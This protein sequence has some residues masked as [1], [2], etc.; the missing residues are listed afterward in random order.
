M[1]SR[2]YMSPWFVVLAIVLAVAALIFGF[3][4]PRFNEAR[5]QVVDACPWDTTAIQSIQDAP[6]RLQFMLRESS[7]YNDRLFTAPFTP[8]GSEL[9]AEVLDNEAAREVFFACFQTL[10]TVSDRDMVR[11]RADFENLFFVSEWQEYITSRDL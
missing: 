6:A 1:K 3:S 4:R 9:I 10:Y 2:E 7:R 5:D 11:V 8:E